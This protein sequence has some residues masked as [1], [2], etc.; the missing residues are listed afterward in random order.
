MNSHKESIATDDLT[1]S[2]MYEYPFG[3]NLLKNNIFMIQ[4]TNVICMSLC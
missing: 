3:T 4:L 1:S 2:I